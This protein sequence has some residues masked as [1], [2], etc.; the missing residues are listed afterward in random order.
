MPKLLLVVQLQDYKT[1]CLSASYEEW[2]KN[3]YSLAM[4]LQDKD[5]ELGAF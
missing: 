3:P 4:I 5:R 1:F 2:C